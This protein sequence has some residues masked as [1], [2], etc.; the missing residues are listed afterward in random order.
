MKAKGI[1]LAA[2]LCIC[3]AL[4]AGCSGLMSSVV[5]PVYSRMTLAIPEV[6]RD[7][8]I[9]FAMYTVHDGV[10]KMTAQL[11]PL[12]EG[13]AREV[14]LQIDRGGAWRTVDRAPVVERG[15]TAHLRVENWDSSRD[16]RYRLRHGSSALYEGII[17][18][19]P[20]SKETITVAAFT[21]NAIYD[22]AGGNIP[23]DDIV[24][25]L[26]R[27]KPD[28]LFFSGDQVYDHYWHLAY[29]LRFGR[30]FGEVIGSTPSVIIPD[31]HDV[32]Q[33]NLWGAGGKK[34]HTRS[35][36]DGGYAA[37]IDYVKMVERAQTSH[38]PDPHDPRPVANGIG[39]Y[40]TDL[41]L[42]GVSFAIV[43]D[44]KFK[45]PPPP[46]LVPQQA[47]R[48]DHIVRPGYDPAALDDPG[49]R[50]LGE[51]QLRFL[52]EWAAD[53]GGCYMK[54]VLSQTIFACASHLSGGRDYR[55]YAD[56]D[57]NGW[58]QSGRNRAL[59]TIRKAFAVMIAG[60]QHLATVIHHG[61][62]E[63]GDAGYSFCV[64]SIANF[65]L[66]WW[67]PQQPGDNRTPGMPEHLGNFRDG[68][69]N[70]IR[71]IAV[72]NPSRERNHDKLTTRAAG[73]GIVRFNKRERTVTFECWP[74]NTDISA[75]D[76]QQYAGWPV[77][78]RQEENYGREPAGY[79]PRL[80]VA[81]AEDPVMKIYAQ[82]TGEL[83]YALRIDGR[84]WDPG[85]F[86][87]GS[88]RMVVIHGQERREFRGLTPAEEPGEQ[89]IRLD[90]SPR[91]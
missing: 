58:P 41:T 78:V 63:P 69:G 56:L 17:R 32:G 30:E 14:R 29:W 86:S 59:R 38:L 81:G 7:E 1:R 39:V 21:G 67:D 20:V 91:D 73:F 23:K 57:S 40:Y 87:G 79:L 19:D 49:A 48:P 51:R 37:P 12:K 47:D 50:L 35:G 70:P 75:P 44:R 5:L 62:T 85:V 61:V 13:E 74:R 36:S 33:D 3:T 24:R 65:H 54:A 52:E 88:Y 55:V 6:P 9:C 60:D 10:L 84:R 80:H 16:R 42:G 22:W 31:D 34:S 8:V 27:I 25:N 89:V 83:L 53:W 72:A 76:A 77:T 18:K 28:L 11:Y 46:D 68:F 90:M 26:R 45:S 82:E 15:W 4:L 66:R 43:E 2:G 71:M 64:P